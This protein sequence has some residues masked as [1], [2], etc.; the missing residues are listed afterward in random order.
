M[1]NIINKIS[2]VLFGFFM[3]VPAF[4]G[5]F[6]DGCDYNHYHLSEILRMIAVIF[7]LLSVIEYFFDKKHRKLCIVVFVIGIVLFL[8]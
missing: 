2:F 1:K 4:A 8:F 6:Y 7:C 5:I 3:A